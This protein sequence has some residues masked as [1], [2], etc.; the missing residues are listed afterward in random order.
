LFY[1]VISWGVCRRH[2]A[3]EYPTRYA[4]L[5]GDHS[6]IAMDP[7]QVL[8]INAA[9]SYEEASSAYRLR[10]QLRHPDRHQ[11][12]SQ[13][14]LDEAARETRELNDAWELVKVQIRSRNE[15]RQEPTSQSRSQPSGDV[16]D[17]SVEA[18]GEITTRMAEESVPLAQ[19][20]QSDHDR[21]AAHQMGLEVARMQ[22]EHN[23]A[24]LDRAISEGGAIRISRLREAIAFSEKMVIAAESAVRCNESPA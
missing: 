5:L 18:L 14:V 12:S 16:G 3:T 15:P 9:S 4:P 7:W 6:A 2:A 22:L 17:M 23:K 10:L 20:A 11:G 8:G 13:A 21:L 1:A 24:Y 19:E